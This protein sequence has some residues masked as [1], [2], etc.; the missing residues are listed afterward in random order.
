MKCLYWL[1]LWVS[2]AVVSP[3]SVLC[4]V[5]NL[6]REI[7]SFK[8]CEVDREQTSD[9]FMKFDEKCSSDVQ[10]DY[11]DTQSY[12]FQDC[13]DTTNDYDELEGDDVPHI[14]IF[15]YYD[16]DL[17]SGTLEYSFESNE[18]ISPLKPPAPSEYSP[19]KLKRYLREKYLELDRL[20]ITVDENGYLC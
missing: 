6:C 8:E 20:G 12:S 9:L 11:D 4:H 14:P 18:I 15:P 19:R 17:Y 13:C 7:S 1:H 5:D 16:N 2:A 10:D 3:P